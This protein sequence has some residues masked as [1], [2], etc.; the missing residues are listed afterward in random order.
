MG[1][2]LPSLRER[3]KQ[4]TRVEIVRKAFELF[5]KHGYDGVPVEMICTAVGIS[6]ATFFNYFP[7]KDLILR[8]I[9]RSRVEKLKAIVAR[10][11]E[12][13]KKPTFA[14][15]VS[16][17]V[18]IGEENARIANRSRRLVLDLWFQQVANGPMMA[19][20]EEALVSLSGAIER[21]P[22]RRAASAQLMAETLFAIYMAT[23]LEWLI[24]DDEPV[25]WLLD[26]MRARLE[27]AVKGMQ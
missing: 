12:G 24:R 17:F 21:I 15:V 10:F 18:E 4:R 22:Q 3:Q 19:S 20:R 27:L 14:D 8:E 7:K 9:A 25:N 1:S 6:R 5:A 2:S 13:G 23:M 16:L 11:A 26:N